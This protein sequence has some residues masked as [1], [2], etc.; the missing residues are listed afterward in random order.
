MEE[1]LDVFGIHD[2][3]V[4][5]VCDHPTFHPGRCAGISKDGRSIALI[6]E[7]HPAVC[8]NYEM[9]TRAYLGRIDLAALFELADVSDR[10]YHPLP[11]FPASTRDLALL[12][13]DS[14]PMLTIEKA[15]SKAIGKILESI[16]LF[17]CYKGSQ[18]PEGKKS[19]AFAISMRASDRTLTDSE[20]NAAMDKAL[21]AVKALGCELR[22]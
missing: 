3:D 4:A 8:A 19:L 18:I 16:S 1:L 7:A 9:G 20:V 17:D 15:V 13:D 2:Y 14:L 10:V 22:M 11:R 21:A 12:C 5:A 6:G